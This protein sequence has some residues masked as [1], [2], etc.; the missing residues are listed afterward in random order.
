MK[1]QADFNGLFA[2]EGGGLVLCLSHGDTCPDESGNE[3]PLTQGLVAT[4]FEKDVDDN[5][6]RD[7]LIAN[8]VVT[9]SPEFM[10]CNGSK[11]ALLV[12]E[13]GWYHESDVNS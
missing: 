7:D 4:A 5:G 11:W 6:K 12:D 10:H 9:S 3:I 1:L 2:I 8:G 13:R